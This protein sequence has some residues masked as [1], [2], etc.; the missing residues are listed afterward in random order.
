MDDI[1]T[2]LV[3]LLVLVLMALFLVGVVAF[4]I[5]NHANEITCLTYGYPSVRT[6]VVFDWPPFTAF[7]VRRV[8]DHDEVIPVRDL[9][10]KTK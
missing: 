2:N 5:V 6:V 1:W 4:G 9:K 7:C 3:V 10:D 8:Y